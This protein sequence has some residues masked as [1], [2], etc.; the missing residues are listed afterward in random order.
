MSVDGVMESVGNFLDQ[1]PDLALVWLP[2]IFFG[3]IVYLLWRTLQIMPR[4]KPQT[5]EPNS[6]SSVNWEDVAGLEEVKEELG[7]VVEFLQDPSRFER[8]GAR[9]LRPLLVGNAPHLADPLRPVEVGHGQLEHAEP[10]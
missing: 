3:M 4:I 10:V 9:V 5:V 1:A 7:E 2:I 6:R 8:L